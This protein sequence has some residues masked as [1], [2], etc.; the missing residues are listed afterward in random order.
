MTPAA[1]IA[2]AIEVLDEIGDAGRAE[3]ALKTWARGHRFAGSKDRAAIRDHVFDVLRAKRSLACH[4]GGNDG[5]ALMMGLLRRDAADI[6]AAFSGEGYGPDPLSLSEREHL[7]AVPEMTIVQEADLP[8][9][10]WAQWS[11]SLGDEALAVA[12][13]LQSR[14]PISLRVNMRRTTRDDAIAALAVDG[15]TALGVDDVKTALQVTQNE[16]RIKM[17]ASYMDGRVELQDVASQMSVMD[18]SLPCPSRILDYCAGGGGKALAL[19][20]LYDADVIAH[21]I[22]PQRMND[23]PD[24]AERAEVR[25][26]VCQPGQLSKTEPFDLVFCDA[27]CSGSGTWRRAPEAKWQLTPELLSHYNDMQAEVIESAARKVADG[28]TLVYATCSVLHCENEH[29]IDSF[30]SDNAGWTIVD[31][32]RLQ[33]TAIHDGFFRS[34]LQQKKDR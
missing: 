27:P 33:P 29:I 11:E 9:W 1:R 6:D 25:I 19:A 20:D 24:R 5:R 26:Q 14:A 22:A 4:G 3:A 16:R 28:G 15:I 32:W 8:D 31:Q 7:K 2:A 18:L 12:K 10:L 21:D 17:S 30:L 13:M 34:V 23:L